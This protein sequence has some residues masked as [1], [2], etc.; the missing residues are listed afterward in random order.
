MERDVFFDDGEPE[1]PLDERFRRAEQLS[2]DLDTQEAG[3]TTFMR[4]KSRAWVCL[5]NCDICPR[6]DNSDNRK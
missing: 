5:G 1:L 6:C 4:P 3:D 2:L